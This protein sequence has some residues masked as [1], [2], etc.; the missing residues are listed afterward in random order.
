MS[1]TVVV[2]GFFGDEGKGHL[3]S[4]LAMKDKPSI[5]VRGGVGPNAGH[6]VVFQGKT[7]GLR[8]VPCGFVSPSSRLLIGPGVLVN[9]KVLFEEMKLTGTENRLG[10]DNQCAIIEDK[11]IEEEKRNAHLITKIGTTKTGVGICQSERVYRRAKVAREFPELSRYL[12]DVPLEV[13][14]ALCRKETVLVEGTQGT[15]ISL[16]HGTYPYVTAK[17]VCSSAICSDVGIG[18]TAVDDVVVV[19]KAFVTR[20]GE[21]PLENQLSEEELRKRGWLEFGTVTGRPRRAAPFDFKLAKRAVMLNGATQIAITKLDI[22]YPECN[23]V[24]SFE[25]LSDASR[26]FIDEV[27]SETGVPVTLLG[28]GPSVEDT[29]DRR[30]L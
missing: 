26:R 16:Y 7:Y 8:M 22:V 5:T 1:C 2:G 21:G 24:R 28:T 4:Y 29:V 27:E 19:F 17:D 3:V 15:Y 20:V 6:K 11:H 12:A 30:K 10:V 9:P 18:P 25:K 13:G 23:G 14:E